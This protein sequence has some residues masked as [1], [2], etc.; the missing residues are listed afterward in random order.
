VLP[1]C[2]LSLARRNRAAPW[3]GAGLGILVVWTLTSPMPRFLIQ[4]LP[5]LC[6]AAELAIIVPGIGPRARAALL[7]VA[8]TVAGVEAARGWADIWTDRPARAG[9]A[10]ALADPGA[11]RLDRLKSFAEAAEWANADLPAGACVIVCGGVFVHPLGRRAFGGAEV[12]PFQLLE[13]AASSFGPRDLDRRVRQTGITHLFYDR[14]AAVNHGA[15]LDCLAP[16]DRALPIW[17]AWWRS[18]AA[19]V[20]E[21]RAF[22]PVHGAFFVY[23]IGTRPRAAE[24]AGAR[25]VLPGIEGW[26]HRAESMRQAG[27]T[28]EAR[29][30]FG[31]IEAAAGDFAI[32]RQARV[33]IFEADLPPAEARRILKGVEASGLRSVW[34]LTMLARLADAG[35]DRTEAAAY[36]RKARL[37]MWEP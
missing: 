7:S 4:A 21:S 23:A 35:G 8:V 20:H 29:A 28:A 24:G 12:E 25:L 5:I 33:A 26:F 13:A 14:I 9:V 19:L 16:P 30:V 11:Y 34:C 27:R 37:L 6:G 10:L 36:R 18:R 17:A 15:E 31:R 2:L 32:V 3:A 22:D 1:A